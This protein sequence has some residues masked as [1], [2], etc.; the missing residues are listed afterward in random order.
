M[1]APKMKADLHVHSTASDG[2]LSPAELVSLAMDRGLDVM[3]IADHDSVGGITPALDAARDT[4]LVLVPAVELSAVHGGRDIHRLA[5]FVDHTSPELLAHLSDL[6]EARLRR[7]EAMVVALNSAGYPVAL[8]DVL[9]MSGGGAVG[10]SHVARALV[11]AG[12]AE[13]VSDAFSR[14]IGR[15]RPFYVR[16]DARSPKDVLATIVA[17]GAVPVLAHP[18]VSGATDLVGQL[19]AMGL[20]GLEAYHADHTPAQRDSLLALASRFD[21]LVTGGTDYHGPGAPNPDL[22]STE[23]PD[24]C[25]RALLEAGGPSWAARI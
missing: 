11:D 3:A 1:G 14:L 20:R 7:A 4:D 15:G 21:L 6:R 17:S 12:H 18:G 24:A 10:R 9:A 23:V 8:D 2:S 16:K 25:V 13:T 22:G 19:V 5:Y